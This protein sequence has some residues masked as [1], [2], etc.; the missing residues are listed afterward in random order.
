MWLIPPQLL[1]AA[2]LV[3]L[4]RLLV[5][6][7]GATAQGGIARQLVV[8]SLTATE[9][10]VAFLDLDGCLNGRCVA[11][12]FLGQ[13]LH[14]MHLFIIGLVVV[15]LLVQIHIGVRD[16][17]EHLGVDVVQLAHGAVGALVARRVWLNG[18]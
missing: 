15:V 7:A 8:H 2:M 9:L 6:G 17:R 14:G 5:V 18:A 11:V 10:G 1:H 3:D 13:V 4:H 16:I 12:P